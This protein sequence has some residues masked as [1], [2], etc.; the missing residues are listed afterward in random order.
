MEILYHTYE[1]RFYHNFIGAVYYKGMRYMTFLLLLL[2]P[3]RRS[4]SRID[5]D[6]SKISP[7]ELLNSL[8]RSK[9]VRDTPDITTCLLY[10]DPIVRALVWG[11]KSKRDRHAIVCAG[12]ILAERLKKMLGDSATALLT[13]PPTTLPFIIIPIPISQTRRRERGYNQC[14]LV[15]REMQLHIKK[16]GINI[17]IRTDILFRSRQKINGKK[18]MEK[19]AFKN[20]RERIEGMRGAFFVRT[21]KASVLA[22]RRIIIIDDV[23]T[24]GSTIREAVAELRKAGCEHVSALALAH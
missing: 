14:E 15:A 8:P 20:R 22:S 13:D 3:N 2:F 21:E 23:L 9:E 7:E 1:W 4:A 6:F 10:K 18:K 24:T 17:E 11:I 16:S 5:F 12:F 19:Q